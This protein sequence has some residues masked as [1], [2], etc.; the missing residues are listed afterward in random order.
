RVMAGPATRLLM[1]L[2][3]STRNPW[4]Q[5][6]AGSVRCEV[7]KLGEGA[8]FAVHTPDAN[9]MVHGTV[10][11]VE[12][13]AAGGPRQTCVRVDEGVVSVLRSDREDLLTHGQSS[14]CDEVALPTPAQSPI[15]PADAVL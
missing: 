14:G 2:R 12:I 11:S 3:A 1:D 4:V 6:L 15:V 10:F 7:P 13:R 9:V 5:L 8:H